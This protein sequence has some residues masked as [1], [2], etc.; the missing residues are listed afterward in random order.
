MRLNELIHGQKNLRLLSGEPARTEIADITSDSREAGFNS[1]FVAIPGV[2]QDGYQ[3]ISHAIHRGANVVLIPKGVNHHDIPPG[4]IIL[5][6]D[7][8]RRALSDL[9]ARLYPR[10]PATIA[11]VTGTNGKTSVAAFTQ[12][13]WSLTS[14]PAASIGTLGIKTPGGVEYGTHTTPDAVH[15]HRSL[16]HLAKHGIDHVALEASSHGLEQHRLDNIRLSAAAFTNL[17]H[18]HL[19]Y[20]ETMEKYFTAKQI[21]FRDILPPGAAAIIN[22]DIEEALALK[23]ICKAR[24]HQIISFGQ[25]GR[26]IRLLNIRH[27]PQG[28]EL[29]LSIFETKAHVIFPMFGAFQAYNLLAALGLVI[30][31]NEKADRLLGFIPSLVSVRGR[32]E[33]IGHT[34]KGASVYVDYAHK[35]LALE[36]VLQA[37]RPSAR[38]LQV[39]FGCGGDRDKG[40]RPLMG[41]IAARIAD[42]VYV[43]DDNPRS[44][45]PGDIRKAIMEACSKAIEIGDRAQAIKEAIAKLEA[46]DI[47]LIAGK[48]HETGQ[49]IGDVVH[50]FD[51][52]EVVR[53]ILREKEGCAA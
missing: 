18:E 38:S 36:N 43:T 29:E 21:L 11:A 15:L 25:K 19:D 6:S 20:H 17:S 5:E 41:E 50:P 40:K 31:C 10:Q 48:G 30:G 45:N 46:G 23:K 2:K 8:P 51:D 32:L 12:Q 3:F 1:L 34:Q 4:V 52:A 39:V 14:R 9:A 26:D 37:L 16:H 7:N 27:I 28:Q 33:F 24:G 22:E 47:L 42:R 49:I 13:L 53:R 44:E 35:P